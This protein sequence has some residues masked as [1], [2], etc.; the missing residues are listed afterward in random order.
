MLILYMYH[1]YRL[2]VGE[3]QGWG[4]GPLSFPEVVGISHCLRSIHFDC[5]VAPGFVTCQGGR[6][7]TSLITFIFGVLV[8]VGKKVAC[9]NVG[10]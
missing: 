6:Q 1:R 2:R 3:G 7:P 10:L 8:N 5:A 9:L 4:N